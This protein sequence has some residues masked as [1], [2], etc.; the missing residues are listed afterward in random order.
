MYILYLDDSGSHDNKN[1]SHAVLGG[2][3]VA[4]EKIILG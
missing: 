4:E 3:I 1:E 2:F